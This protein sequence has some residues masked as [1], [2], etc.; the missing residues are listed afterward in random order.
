[1]CQNKSTNSILQYPLQHQAY[2]HDE[3]QF[4]FCQVLV[5]FGINDCYPGLALHKFVLQK[6]KLIQ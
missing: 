2:L 6:S 4:S 3:M 5:S 1:M